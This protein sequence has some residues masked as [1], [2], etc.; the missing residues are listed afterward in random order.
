MSKISSAEKHKADIEKQIANEKSKKTSLWNRAKKN[1]RLSTL[2]TLLGAANATLANLSTQA[3]ARKQ[4]LEQ[5][6]RLLSQAKERQRQKV[7]NHEKKAT[8]KQEKERQLIL[9]TKKQKQVAEQKILDHEAQMDNDTDRMLV[10]PMTEPAHEM[11]LLPPPHDKHHHHK[12]SPIVQKYIRKHPDW[13]PHPDPMT[14]YL[15]EYKKLQEANGET[16]VTTKISKEFFTTLMLKENPPSKVKPDLND[17]FEE[18]NLNDKTDPKNGLTQ[19]DWINTINGINK[20]KKF[21]HHLY[22]AFKKMD[23][24]NSGTVTLQEAADLLV[25][26]AKESDTISKEINHL[27]KFEVTGDGIL[28]LIEFYTMILSDRKDNRQKNAGNKTA[29]QPNT[30][31]QPSTFLVDTVSDIDPRLVQNTSITTNNSK[32]K[33]KNK[34]KNKEGITR[35]VPLVLRA[36]NKFKRRK[37]KKIKKDKDKKDKDKTKKTRDTPHPPHPPSVQIRQRQTQEEAEQQKEMIKKHVINREMYIRQEAQALTDRME[38]KRCDDL[39]IRQSSDDLWRSR[40]NVVIQNKKR[41]DWLLSETEGCASLFRK[42]NKLQVEESLHEYY[43]VGKYV[44]N[45]IPI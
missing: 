12:N 7:I 43:K 17:L 1:K 18:L 39:V 25:G 37:R 15:L 9:K 31:W 5:Q 22:H 33:N 36:K 29:A 21:I 3:E 2:T 16:G 8:K 23:T 26:N 28:S 10:P 11:V 6:Q 45:L 35:T 34:N 30:N 14:G 32:N 38:Q 27:K 42:S 13:K 20:E 40:L 44:F 24:D 41:H 19:E 4:A